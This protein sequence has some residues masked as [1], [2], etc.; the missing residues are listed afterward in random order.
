V[1]SPGPFAHLRS[2][3]LARRIL[4]VVAL[5]AKVLS[6]IINELVAGEVDSRR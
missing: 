1:S 4:L 5:A 2:A 3:T 6:G